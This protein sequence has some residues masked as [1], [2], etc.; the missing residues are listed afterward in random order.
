MKAAISKFAVKWT[1][2]MP[3]EAEIAQFADGLLRL[4]IPEIDEVAVKAGLSVL[5]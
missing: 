3:P 5:R 4:Q 2:S 1:H